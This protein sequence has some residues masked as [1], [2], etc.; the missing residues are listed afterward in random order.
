LAVAIGFGENAVDVLT[1]ARLIEQ[2]G[3]G[4]TA[5]SLATGLRNRGYAQLEGGR[6]DAAIEDFRRAVQVYA[7]LVEQ[8]GHADLA[9]QLA[10][11][12]NSVAW[13]YATHPQPAFRD[14]G[15]AKQYA[16]LACN[17]SEWKAFAPVESLAAACAETDDFAGAVKWQLKALELAPGQ[18]QVELRS[19]LELYRSDIPTGRRAPGGMPSLKAARA[20][21]LLRIVQV[22]M[23]AARADGDL[24]E[25][26]PKSGLLAAQ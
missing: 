5:V 15:K 16:L 22:P 7:R 26:D 12:V 4:E 20:G 10:K 1:R 13:L 19:R 2:G 14:G 25:A 24:Q 6:P 23:R 21:A 9:P 8:E 17:L 18:H 11:S 3:R